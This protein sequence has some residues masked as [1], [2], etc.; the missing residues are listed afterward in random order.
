VNPVVLIATHKRVKVT[1]INI[2]S[3]LKQSLNP[4]ICVVCSDKE[5]CVHFNN[6]YERNLDVHIVYHENMPLG[7]KWQHGVNHCRQYLSA[8]P[9]IITGSDDILGPD[10][11]KKACEKVK[12]GYDFIGLRE[13]FVIHDKFRY[14]LEYKPEMPLGAG[15]VYS[16][17]LLDLL[18]WRIFDTTKSKL[19]DD[20]GWHRASKAKKHIVDDIEAEGMTIESIKGDWPMLNPFEKMIRHK[21]ITVIS[22]TPL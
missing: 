11:V 22:K 13:W 4:I 10:F 12:E 8:D 15:R 5:E 19:L 3:L 7:R 16:K 21:N 2:D 18:G 6:V 9:L 20:L 14:K 1:C 17:K